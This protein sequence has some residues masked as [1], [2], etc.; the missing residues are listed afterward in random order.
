MAFNP[1][2]GQSPINLLLFWA[3]SFFH[4]STQATMKLSST[5]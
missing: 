5:A 1:L 4:I 2:G 3:P